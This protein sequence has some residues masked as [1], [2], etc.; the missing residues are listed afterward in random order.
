MKKLLFLIVSSIFLYS[1]SLNLLLNKIEKNSD[2]SLK[3]KQEA[4]GIS[5]VITRYQLDMMQAKTLNDVLKNTVISN[6]QNRYNLLDPFSLP[7]SPFGNNNIKIFIDNYEINSM[8]SEN[9]SFLFTNLSLDFVD[10]IEIYYFSSADKYFGEPTYVVIKLYSKSPKRDN[11]LTLKNSE[12]RKIDSQ[13]FEY[14]EYQKNLCYLYGS[15]NII[16]NQDYMIESKQVHKNSKTYHFFSKYN[17]NENKFIFN[18]IID[19]RDGFLGMSADGKPDIS[20]IRNKQFLLGYNRKFDNFLIN[21][22]TTFQENL[23]EFRENDKAL[24]KKDNKKIYSMFTKGD[25]F[26]NTLKTN[27]K[28]LKNDKNDVEIGTILKNQ[29][30]IKIDYKINDEQDF[31][32]IKKQTQYTM[33]LNNNYQYSKNYILNASLS[34][35]YYDNDVVYDYKLSNFKIGNTYLFNKENI[36]KLFYFHIENIPPNYLVNSI[37]QNSTLKLT[38]TNSYI[39]K[40]KRDTKEYNFN[41]T[42]VTGNSRNQIISKNNGLENQKGEMSLNFIDVSLHKTYNYI[43]DIILEAFMTFIDN[44]PIKKQHQISL[45]NT[46]RYNKFSFFENIIYRYIYTNHTNK[47]LD[48]DLGVKYNVSNNLTLSFRANSILNSRYENEYQRY[49]VD[50]NKILEPFKLSSTPRDFIFNMEYSF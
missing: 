37:F 46:H 42:Y 16:K 1:Q 38:L 10:H 14:G 6:H 30:N 12:S 28:L 50:T 15:R 27:Y 9:S 44:S 13:A 18:A 24:Y 22:T 41:L 25:N 2:L 48:L 34:F 43:N 35:S 17:K 3:T 23:D 47:G 33:F 11:G 8:A 5:Y 29:H 40:Y 36:V 7:M 39:L 32:G 45:L 20:K 19:K 49:D 31:N 26:T 21:Y 4:A